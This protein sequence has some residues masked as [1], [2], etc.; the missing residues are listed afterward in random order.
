MKS[1]F[2]PYPV[3]NIHL[4]IAFVEMLHSEDMLYLKIKL[5]SESS[6]LHS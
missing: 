6:R 1:N 3:V 5:I 2:Y 4:F